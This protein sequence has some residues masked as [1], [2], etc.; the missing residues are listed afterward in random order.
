MKL[1]HVRHDKDAV[2]FAHLEIRLHFQSIA[3]FFVNVLRRILPNFS[4]P[5]KLFVGPTLSSSY[6]VPGG[7]DPG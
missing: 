1:A 4:E 2:V 6:R 3:I 5:F 7:W